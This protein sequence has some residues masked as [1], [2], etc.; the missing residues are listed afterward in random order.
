M[1]NSYI[2]QVKTPGDKD[3]VGNGMRFPTYASADDYV[4]ALSWRWTAVIDTNVGESDDPV[5]C[6]EKGTLLK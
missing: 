5:N 6:D 4:H 2:P 3:W 1:A